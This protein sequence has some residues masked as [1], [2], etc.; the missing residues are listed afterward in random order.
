[1]ACVARGQAGGGD[2]LQGC[3]SALL[4]GHGR[5]RWVNALAA[6]FMRLLM[7]VLVCSHSSSAL[8]HQSWGARMASGQAGSYTKVCAAAPVLQVRWGLT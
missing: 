3:A 6:T 7:P 4:H 5:V 1:M 2:E 8:L